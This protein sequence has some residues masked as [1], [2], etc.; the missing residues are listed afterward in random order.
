MPATFFELRQIYE[1]ASHI[2]SPLRSF[3]CSTAINTRP[4]ANDLLDF[5]L[6]MLSRTFIST[7]STHYQLIHNFSILYDPFPF[8]W[9]D[10]DIPMKPF[11]FWT[12]DIF[13]RFLSSQICSSCH[14]FSY[15]LLYFIVSLDKTVCRGIFFIQTIFFG[16]SN[17]VPSRGRNN[18]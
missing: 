3:H 2:C 15:A 4:S 1:G 7:N 8:N 18:L 5:S 12:V 10:L 13:F 6:Q 14:F 16:K 11:Y 9:I 17:R